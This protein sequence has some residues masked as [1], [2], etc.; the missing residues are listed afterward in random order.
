MKLLPTRLGKILNL[1]FASVINIVYFYRDEGMDR[2]YK[3]VNLKFKKRWTNSELNTNELDGVINAKATL[4]W[5]IVN[6]NISSLFGYPQSAL[7]V[8]EKQNH[9][10]FLN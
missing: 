7:S 4:G 5:H 3:T 10:E 2:E 1:L 8:Y 9:A 6:V